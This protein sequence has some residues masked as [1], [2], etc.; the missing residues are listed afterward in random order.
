MPDHNCDKLK[1]RNSRPLIDKSSGIININRGYVNIDDDPDGN[2][3]LYGT[4]ENGDDF[5]LYIIHCP[6]CG[7]KLKPDVKKV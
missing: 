2:P 1:E 4:D 3:H 7:E 5:F 6:Y